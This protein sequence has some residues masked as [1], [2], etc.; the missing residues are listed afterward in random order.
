[1]AKTQDTPQG[2][3]TRPI[4]H[5]IPALYANRFQVWVD[6]G[7]VRIIFGDTVSGLVEDQEFRV[8]FVMQRNDAKALADVINEL[9]EQTNAPAQDG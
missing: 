8:A 3:G 6:G 1:M 9:L 2:E 7:I 4:G 5:G